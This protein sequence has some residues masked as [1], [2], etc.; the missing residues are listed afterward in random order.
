MRSRRRRAARRGTLTPP[1]PS[2]PASP[3][4]A[5]REGA[6]RR[7]ETVPLFSR[8]SG[9]R[10]GEEGWGDEGSRQRQQRRPGPF[11]PFAG[12]GGHFL[13]FAHKIERLGGFAQA[14]VLGAVAAHGVRDPG[15]LV[16]GGE[17]FG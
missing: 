13:V 1:T 7:L 17:I 16:R 15:R 8:R 4:A 9:G 3:P 2:L 11:G 10:L 6:Q 12:G 5:G 14:R